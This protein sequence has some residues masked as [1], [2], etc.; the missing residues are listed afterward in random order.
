MITSYLKIEILEKRPLRMTLG[1]KGLKVNAA[2]RGMEYAYFV[3]ECVDF[4]RTLDAI[5][6]LYL[7]Y[8]NFVQIK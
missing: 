2:G 3:L 8:S 4:C 5:D 1:L 7:V 6:V